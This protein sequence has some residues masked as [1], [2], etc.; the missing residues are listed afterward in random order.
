MDNF[1]LL[2]PSVVKKLSL[3]PLDVVA[4]LWELF[5]F[6]GL[7]LVFLFGGDFL[8]ALVEVWC[9]AEGFCELTVTCEPEFA[10]SCLRAATGKHCHKN[11]ETKS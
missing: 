10:R 8:F 9:G 5:G 2:L 1:C 4:F 7:G 11:G 3:T 6:L